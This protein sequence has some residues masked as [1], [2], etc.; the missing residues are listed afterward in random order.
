M[1]PVKFLREFADHVHTGGIGE[2][3]QFCKRIFQGEDVS[4]VVKFDAD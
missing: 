4:I 3:S 2:E 1:R